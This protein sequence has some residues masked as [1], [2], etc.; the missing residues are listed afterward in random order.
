MFSRLIVVLVMPLMVIAG[1]ARSADIAADLVEALQLREAF[2][3]MAAEGEAYGR[4]IEA[5]MFPGA[6]G[7]AWTASVAQIYAVESILPQ[8]TAAFS[9]DLARSKSDASAAL[10]FFQS[11]LGRRVTTLEVSARRALLD[12]TVEDASRLKLEEMQAARDPRLELIEEFVSVNDL[13]EA[14]VTGALNASYAFYLGLAEA[15]A[16]G[17]GTDQEGMLSDVWAQEPSIR[18]ETDSWIHSYL[19]MAYAPLSDDDLKEYIAFSRTDAGRDLNRALFFGFDTV[20]VDV[21]RKL[22]R[23]AGRILAGRDL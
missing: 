16:F 4:E 13:I 15:G 12:K 19:V 20:F 17:R 9:S 5:E 23:A 21:S 1:S 14:N 10:G 22:G 8:F 6:G 18:Q 2:G 3:V 7:A 11:D